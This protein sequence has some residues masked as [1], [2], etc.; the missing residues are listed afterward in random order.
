MNDVKTYETL[1]ERQ[2][3]PLRGGHAIYFS[4]ISDLLFPTEYDNYTC[5]I[6]VSC[7]ARYGINS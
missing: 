5:V 3:P 1:L 2:L 7:I 6:F 4:S